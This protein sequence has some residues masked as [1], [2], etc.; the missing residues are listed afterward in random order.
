[1]KYKKSIIVLIVGV[2]IIIGLSFLLFYDKDSAVVICDNVEN[3]ID[4]DIMGCY[5]AYS[6]SIYLEVFRGSDSSRWVG[7]DISFFDFSNKE[8]ELRDVPNFEMSKFYKIDA[9]RNPLS[10]DINFDILEDDC[11]YN[12]NIRIGYCSS[13][14]SSKEINSS[15][16]LISES[17]VSNF[18][19][20]NSNVG[21]S[22]SISLV[23]KDSVWSSICQSN[24]ECTA[25]ESC[26]D[27][28]Q[29]R[30]CN[31]LNSC[32]VPTNIPK[33][34]KYCDGI[35]E[36]SWQCEWSRCKDGFSIPI[37]HDVNKCGTS[38][39]KPGKV[40]CNKKCVPNIICDGW[41]LCEPDYNFGTL[42]GNEYL[43]NG[44][45]YRICRDSNNCA[46]DAR[47]N[48]EC[49]VSVDV[50]IKPFSKC[51]DDFLG[52]YNSLDD[53]LI[54]NFKQG[55][56]NNAFVDIDLSNMATTPYCNY[57]FN[58]FLDGDETD[59][60]CGGSC[61]GCESRIIVENFGDGFFM[62]FWKMI[63]K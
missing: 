27:G 50:Y 14:L 34:M 54:V 42:S 41:S 38:F 39:N 58:G 31:D 61:I 24:W 56:G 52:L 53:S 40:E 57:C 15:L 48:K 33:R 51:G 12:K 63:F 46:I 5:D 21:D 1:M 9:E 59:I 11:N 26:V 10:L 37:C 62:R 36:E 28:I 30:I 43:L 32:D 17:N 20:V 25:W 29:K 44:N 3:I 19:P 23:D 45:Q 55:N 18:V 35:C 49:S 22:V 2:L 60:D 16:K 47:E 6:N 13:E 4:L 8:V 7:M